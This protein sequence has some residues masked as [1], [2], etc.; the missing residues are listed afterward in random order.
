[1]KNFYTPSLGA[2][3]CVRCKALRMSLTGVYYSK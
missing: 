3:K 1:M 2:L